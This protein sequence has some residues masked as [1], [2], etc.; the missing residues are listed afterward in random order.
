MKQMFRQAMIIISIGMVT[1]VVATRIALSEHTDSDVALKIT[2][3][4]S[5][6]FLLLAVIYWLLTRIADSIQNP[7]HQI[8]A[9][10]QRVSLYKDYSLRISTGMMN[11]VPR[12]IASVMESMNAMLEEI[13][14]R[15]KR[16][17]RKT[18]ELEKAR[19]AADVANSAKSHF[20]ANVSH[21]LRTPLN[22]IIG[23]STMMYQE[24]FGSIGNVKYAEYARDI[25]DSG[26]HLLEVINDILDLSNAESGKLRVH[27]ELFSIPKI[28]DKALHIVEGQAMERKIDIYTDFPPKL[29]KIIADR[30][31]LVQILLNLLSNA[32]KHTAEGGKITIRVRSEPGKNDITFFEIEVEDNG[33]GMSKE[34]IAKAFVS[35]NQADASLARKY[36]GTGLGLPLIKRLVDLHHGRIKINSTKGLGTTVTMRLPSNPALLD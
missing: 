28:I 2:L 21:E 5:G 32:L 26:T 23:F 11:Q 25:H 35:F 14:D 1:L 30:V 7:L 36:D 6:G 3:L 8:A 12:E 29:P 20:L 22:A 24:K 16:L 13:E 9:A 27:F 34:E 18:I 4:A 33:A 31:R 19:Q 15:D 17:T 10:A